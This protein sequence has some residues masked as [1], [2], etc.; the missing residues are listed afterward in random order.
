[1][2]RREIPARSIAAGSRSYMMVETMIM[3][4]RP[5]CHTAYSA[6]TKAEAALPAGGH[7]LP[8]SGR[9]LSFSKG[10]RRFGAEE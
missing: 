2:G 5:H 7:A 1:M 3:P 4:P 10:D 6:G 9:I 8:G